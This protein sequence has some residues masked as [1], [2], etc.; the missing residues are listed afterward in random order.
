MRKY[1]LDGEQAKQYSN[2]LKIIRELRREL[3]SYDPKEGDM[4]LI[5]SNP[6]RYKQII[7]EIRV[8]ER[9]NE[10]MRSSQQ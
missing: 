7:D 2:N 10:D 9:E 3:K 8:L 5:Q 1:K 4:E 6:R